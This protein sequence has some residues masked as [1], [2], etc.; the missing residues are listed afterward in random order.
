MKVPNQAEFQGF[1]FF[2]AWK[3]RDENGHAPMPLD[4]L[5]QAPFDWIFVTLSK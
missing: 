5:N 1:N 4:L 2:K 3:L